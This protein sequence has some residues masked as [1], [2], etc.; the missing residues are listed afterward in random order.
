[1]KKL[2]LFALTLSLSAG[3]IAADLPYV[4]ADV[5]CLETTRADKYIADLKIDIASFGGKE[6]CDAKSDAKKILTDIYLVE[7]GRFSNSG[8]NV[9]INGFVGGDYYEYLKRETY[10][11]DRKND[12]PYASAYN[13]GG[14][15]TFQDGWAQS[16]TLGRVG[17]IIHEA[18][19]TEG[20]RHVICTAGPYMNTTVSGC[21]T[22]L[23]QG[24]SHGVEMEYY[25]RVVVQGENF[26]PVYRSMARLMALGRSNIFFN[27]SPLKRREA[28]V[29]L[30]QGTSKA[31]L[32]DNGTLTERVAPATTGVLKR[33]SFGA[34]IFDGN[35][36]WSLDLYSVGQ[37]PSLIKDA[38]SYLKMLD[39]GDTAPFALKDLEEYDVG[40]QRYL[41]AL[42]G[43]NS[44]ISYDFPNGTWS[45]PVSAANLDPQRLVTATPDGRP[46]VFVLTKAGTLVPFDAT[47]RRLGSALAATWPDETRNL[48]KYQSRVLA[49]RNDGSLVST[50]ASAK[51]EP[52][53]AGHSLSQVVTAPL[54]DAFEVR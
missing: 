13:S 20:Y 23:R 31:L 53:L 26:H 36:A 41:V 47:T 43:N 40:T 14:Y 28:L 25:A 21:D 3:A 5:G 33:T 24:G 37:G 4:D 49:L 18:R 12:V 32:V 7:E 48:V 46:G 30:E 9:F 42:T 45:K 22:S 39:R 2:S 8:S 16:S 38:Y 44:L 54:Y 29:A 17:T 10:G 19:H 51:P 50:D 11:M 1:M 6:L 52:T 35:S 34:A 15:F 27:D